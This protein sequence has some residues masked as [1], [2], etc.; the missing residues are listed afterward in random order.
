MRGVPSSRHSS[1][2]RSCFRR[3]L[4]DAFTAIPDYTTHC[5]VYLAW[6]LPLLA[7]MAVHLYSPAL[8]RRMHGRGFAAARCRR[9]EQAAR[10]RRGRLRNAVQQG[11][12]P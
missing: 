11:P 8:G 7:F 6:S 9:F 2:S 12:Q 4:A 3:R 1:R 5:A 10:R